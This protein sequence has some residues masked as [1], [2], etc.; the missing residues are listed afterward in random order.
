M[1]GVPLCNCRIR[2]TMA[3]CVFVTGVFAW[4]GY[5]CASCQ[6]GTFTSKLQGWGYRITS[7]LVRDTEVM[8]RANAP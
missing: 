1:S 5:F 4:Q 8:C 7:R 6:S 2:K 3:S